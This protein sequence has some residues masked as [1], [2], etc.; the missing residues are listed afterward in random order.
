MLGREGWVVLELDLAF[1][2]LLLS[3]STEKEKEKN[4]RLRILFIYFVPNFGQCERAKSPTAMSLG[5]EWKGQ[6]LLTSLLLNNFFL[7]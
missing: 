3:F 4:N 5:L 2:R 7:I 1:V 6:I